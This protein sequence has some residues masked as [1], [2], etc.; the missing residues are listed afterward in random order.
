MSG[1][2]ALPTRKRLAGLRPGQ[3]PPDAVWPAGRLVVPVAACL[4]VTLVVALFLVQCSGSRR[5]ATASPNTTVT[6]SADDVLGRFEKPSWY[7]N[8]SGP[9]RLLN[10]RNLQLVDELNVRLVRVWALPK[11]YYNAATGRYDFD[12]TAADG[13]TAYEYFDQAVSYADRMLVNLGEC[14]PSIL[15]LSNPGTCRAV[16]RAGLLAYKKR[17]PSIQYIELFNEP[18]KIWTVPPSDWIGLS[19]DDYYQW[20]RIGY[21]VV[22]DV[23]RELHPAA[24]LRIGGPAA[25][26]FDVPFLQ[27]FLDRYARDPDPEKRLDFLSYHQYQRQED[28][29]RVATEKSTVRGWLSDRGLGPDIPVFV[30][31]CGVFPGTTGGPSLDADLLTQAAA[32]ETLAYYYMNSHMDLVMNWVFRHPDNPRK[33]MFVSDGD[34]KVYPY[35]NLVKMQSMM[36]R[37]RIAARSDGLSQQ[38]IGVNAL[39]TMDGTGIAVLATNYQW[40]DG[41]ESHLVSLNVER[42]PGELAH[43]SLRVDRYLI[44]ATTSNYA[45]DLAS[46]QLRRVARQTVRGGAGIGTVFRLK[47]NALALIVIKPASG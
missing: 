36:K 35:F 4:I 9:T 6:V 12:F 5:A 13:S 1:R 21:S 24:P 39:A 47:P 23:N 38:G 7:Q 22:N 10:P 26:T 41:R 15:T 25:A 27:G 20:Y 32:M 28:P 17:Y 46:S 37:Q 14:D 29:A 3:R 31:E 44:D 33:S 16:L 42:L 43:R 30:T 2:I 8:Q 34:G 19:V 11:G 18:D 40:V 45:H